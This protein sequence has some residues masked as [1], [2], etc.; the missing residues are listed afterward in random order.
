[1]GTND[2]TASPHTPTAT[3]RGYLSVA[4]TA[5]YFGVSERL[6]RAMIANGE[7]PSL[8]IRRRTLVPRAAI[9]AL[10]QTMSGGQ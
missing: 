10:E 1:M 8:K 9:T 6:V 3:E 7:L 5:D 2:S 4:Q